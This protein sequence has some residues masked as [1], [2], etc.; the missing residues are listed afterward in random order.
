MSQSETS[1]ADTTSEKVGSAAPNV[2]DVLEKHLS[3]DPLRN[4]DQRASRSRKEAP[5]NTKSTP[6]SSAPV[7]SEAPKNSKSA[8]A[9]SAPADSEAPKA[10]AASTAPATT[11][12][13][14]PTT[15]PGNALFLSV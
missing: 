4:Q 9:S 8:P 1:A 2:L 3:P 5:K 7:E 14:P 10:T 15:N 13:A 12:P 11:V 6:S